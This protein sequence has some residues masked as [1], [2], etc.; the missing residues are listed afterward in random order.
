VEIYLAFLYLY[1]Q[2]L[3]RSQ[4][5]DILENSG[6]IG[7]D[8]RNKGSLDRT[9]LVVKGALLRPRPFIGVKYIRNAW[10]ERSLQ[11]RFSFSVNQDFQTLLPSPTRLRVYESSGERSMV[12]INEFFAQQSRFNSH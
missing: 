8:G 1:Y 7:G 5:K 6:G 11:F 9:R 4:H 10:I 2:H 3:A 12:H